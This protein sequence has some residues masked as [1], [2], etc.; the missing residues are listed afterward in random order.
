[1]TANAPHAFPEK[2]IPLR[3]ELAVYAR[4]LPRLLDAGDAG[5]YFVA[6][7]ETVHGVWDT[8]HDAIQHGY[9]VV[10]DGRFLAQLID[11][12]FLPLLATYFQ[13]PEEQAL[14]E[15]V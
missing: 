8:Y 11:P 15:A 2:L 1:M 4:E 10:P 14:L 3:T 9:A 12:R 5:K 6:K 7:G 13:V